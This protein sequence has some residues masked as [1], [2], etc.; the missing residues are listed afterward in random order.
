VRIPVGRS[1]QICTQT[2]TAGDDGDMTD[3]LRTRAEQLGVQ[4]TYHDVHGVLHRADDATL[5]RVV[6]VLEADRSAAA[7]TPRV[8]APLHLVGD[9]PLQVGARVSDASLIVAGH[10]CAASV[11]HG[12]P[13]DL[14][15]LP[16]DL[17]LGC[18]LLQFDTD[19]GPGETVVVVHPAAMPRDDRFAR[20]GGLFAPT[21]AL[22]EHT[23]PL[24]SFAHLHDLA[25]AAKANGV[26]VVA[27]LPLYATYL[28]DPFDPSPYSP[29]SRLHWNE[30][31]LDDTGL[32]PA[33]IPVIGETIDWRSL[34]ARRRS[35]L[36]EAVASIGPELQDRLTAFAAAHPDVGA[37][38]RFRAARDAGGDLVVEQSHLLAQFLADEQLGAIRGDTDAA[39]LALDLPIG[40]HS[41]G[42]EVWA[43]PSMFAPGI[44]VGAPPDAFFADGQGWGFPPPLPAAMH[45]SGHRLWRHLVE[46]VGRHADILR[47]DHAMAVHRLWWIP[48]GLPASQGVYV[49]YP[50]EEILAVIAATAAAA[51]VTIVGEDL[52]TVPIEVSDAFERWDVLGMYEEQFHLDDEQLAHIPART[53]AGIRTHDMEPFAELVATSDTSGYRQRLGAAHQRE[54]GDRWDEVVDE[55]LVRLAS[56]DAYLVIADLDDLVGER[57]P[58]NLPGRV[59]PDLWSR[60]LD[61]PTSE[62]LAEPDVLQRLRALARRADDADTNANADARSRA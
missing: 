61:R 28:D 17:P 44:S 52:G 18:H 59:G 47:I 16:D 39:A 41:E 45:A 58:H 5:A 20:A 23:D 49:T 30:V 50:R 36:V 56:S 19:H 22:W 8:A 35:Q 26:D 24:P 3:A 34:A 53:V 48:D 9:G 7:A 57:R 62:T 31:Y 21:Y 54:I 55:M 6:E 60:R 37:Y 46:R 32:P 29:V 15:D 12:D 51:G 11:R 25:R 43:D 4:T 2:A 14:I 10:P 40:S 1:T 38:A 27:T 42:F 33:P 13:D